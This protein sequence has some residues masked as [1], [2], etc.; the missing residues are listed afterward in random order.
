MAKRKPRDD[1]DPAGASVAT[2]LDIGLL[3]ENMKST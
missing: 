1:P 2:M 3:D